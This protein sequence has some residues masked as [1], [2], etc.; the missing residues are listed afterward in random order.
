M[1]KLLKDGKMQNKKDES[2]G[3]GEEKLTDLDKL[4]NEATRN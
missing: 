1:S 2:Q 3:L 4:M